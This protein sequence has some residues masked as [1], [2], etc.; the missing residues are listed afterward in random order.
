MLVVDLPLEDRKILS[1]ILD[2]LL[3]RLSSGLVVLSGEGQGKH[4][5]FISRTKN[6]EKLLS[7]GD[8]LKNIIAPLCKGKGGGKDSFAQGSVTDKSAFF[9][10]EQILLDQWK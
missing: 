7:A 4:P 2:L 3:S 8:I 6:F 1:D 5:V 9:K 10:L